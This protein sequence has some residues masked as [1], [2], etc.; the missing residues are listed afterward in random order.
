[1][2]IGHTHL[3]RKIELQ[4]GGW[5]FNSGTWSDLMRLPQEI[6][7]GTPEEA[8]KKLEPFLFAIENNTLTPWI[9]FRPTYVQLDLDA[10]DRVVS[11][12]LKCGLCHAVFSGPDV[13]ACRQKSAAALAG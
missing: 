13:C 6:I 4:P 7:T 12:E 5:Y 8:R 1:M 11:A 3:A 10:G 2:V 9:I